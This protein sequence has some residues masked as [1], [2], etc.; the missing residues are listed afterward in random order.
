MALPILQLGIE[1]PLVIQ[2]RNQL[3][4]LGFPINIQ[5]TMPHIYDSAVQATVSAFQQ[6][7][8]LAA[9]GVVGPSTWAKL[10]A[11]PTAGDD[12]AKAGLGTLGTIFLAAVAYFGYRKIQKMGGFKAA[13]IGFKQLV[14]SGQPDYSGSD[15]DDDDDDY[16]EFGADD[17]DDDE[18]E[19]EPT[20]PEE[21][22]AQVK[23]AEERKVQ[24]LVKQRLAQE[25][26]SGW[27]QQKEPA[28]EKQRAEWEA[29][30][31]RTAEH[32]AKM[33]AE[34]G[35]YPESVWAER[36]AYLRTE[37]RKEDQRRKELERRRD[38]TSSEAA[39]AREEAGEAYY[40]DL[41]GKTMMFR[42][43]PG[44]PETSRLRRVLPSQGPVWVGSE[45]DPMEREG[46]AYAPARRGGVLDEQ[47][48]HDHIVQI[49]AMAKSNN[50]AQRCEAARI[51]G[52]WA[53]QLGRGELSLSS[54]NLNLL[55]VVVNDVRDQ[56]ADDG[57]AK[58]ERL[59]APGW[60]RSGVPLELPTIL[61][62]IPAEMPRH[63][64]REDAGIRVPGESAQVVE[65]LIEEPARLAQ[66]GRCVEAARVLVKRRVFG[67][68]ALSTPKTQ[69]LFKSSVRMVE[70]YCWPELNEEIALQED[71]SKEWL[72]SEHGQQPSPLLRTQL[73]RRQSVPTE[74][75]NMDTRWTKAMR[76]QMIRADLQNPRD[77]T[78]RTESIPWARREGKWLKPYTSTAE[79]GKVLYEDPSGDEVIGVTVGAASLDSPMITVRSS[80]TGEVSV[81]PKDNII[82]FIPRYATPPKPRPVAERNITPEQKAAHLANKKLKYAAKAAE[83]A[84]A[85]AAKKASKIASHVSSRAA[86]ALQRS[87]VGTDLRP[88]TVRGGGLVTLTGRKL[89]DD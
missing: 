45:R 75:P 23:R 46:A 30:T 53:D 3:A 43:L 84:E 87:V 51:V 89:F 38:R 64:E 9:D 66:E 18:P 57:C 10:G 67:T 79:G 73:K 61:P 83:R 39:R 20:T 72:P 24:K 4:A 16:D 21:L 28:S 44:A 60:S 42:P 1:S 74:N 34:R 86:E 55:S 85:K 5:T 76:A 41:V 63:R 26:R 56:T 22:K 35:E 19:P 7:V 36:P 48:I 50:I 33:K 52:R 17:D 8:G 47:G 80:E 78:P 58:A 82:Q 71:F 62:P 25:R 12:V 69:R 81:I 65:A 88:T 11:D 59:P 14:S 13:F 31:K 40:P 49:T 15:D 70:D 54:A 2:V 29:F 77:L 37:T 32:V 6:S 68:G 27:L